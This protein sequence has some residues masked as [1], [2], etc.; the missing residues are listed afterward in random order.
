MKTELEVLRSIEDLENFKEKSLRDRTKIQGQIKNLHEDSTLDYPSVA[1]LSWRPS[2]C[3]KI[4]Y[5]KE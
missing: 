3:N 1:K 5:D 2:F 4:D